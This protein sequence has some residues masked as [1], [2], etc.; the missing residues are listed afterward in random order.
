MRRYLTSSALLAFSWVKV[1]PSIA[2][3]SPFWVEKSVVLAW[4]LSPGAI[5]ELQA[6]RAAVVRDEAIVQSHL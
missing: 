1:Q 4:L 6:A 2:S 3:V 5:L